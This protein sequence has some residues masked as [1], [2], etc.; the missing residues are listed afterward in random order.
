MGALLNLHAHEEFFLFAPIVHHFFSLVNT[1]QKNFI[2]PKIYKCTFNVPMNTFPI[3]PP[4]II[5]FYRDFIVN[6]CSILHFSYI[7]NK[8]YIIIIDII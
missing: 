8:K 2:F 3:T 5:F 6:V 7:K 1:F 4:Y